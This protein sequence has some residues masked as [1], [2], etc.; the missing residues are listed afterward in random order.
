[1]AKNVTYSYFERTRPDAV[2]PAFAGV[3]ADDRKPI[4][5]L[6]WTRTEAPTDW[7]E[8]AKTISDSPT[9]D[10]AFILDS[11]FLDRHEIPSEVWDSLMSRKIFFTPGIWTELEPWRNTPFA[12]SSFRDSVLAAFASGDEMISLLTDVDWDEPIKK[13]AAYYVSLLAAR[14]LIGHHVIAEFV[15]E[16]GRE[17]TPDELL[18]I[19]QTRVRDRGI[20]LAQK[21]LDDYRKENFLADEELVVFAVFHA[22]LTG[23]ET[24]ILTRDKDVLEQFY[25]FGYLLDTHY[26]SQL[27]ASAYKD[28]PDNLI[29]DELHVPADHAFLFEDRPLSLQLPRRFSEW[30]LPAEWNG[31]NIS[32]VRLGGQGDQMKATHLTFHVE[33]EMQS[34]LTVKGS[35]DG[36]NAVLDDDANCHILISPPF[37]PH[38]GGHAIIA[39][40]RHDSIGAFSGP[41]VDLNYALMEIERFK[42]ISPVTVVENCELSPGCKLADFCII[43][44]MTYSKPSEWIDMPHAELAK[45]I[46]LFNPASIFFADLGF[47]TADHGPDVERALLDKGFATTTSIKNALAS[48]YENK[49]CTR[50]ASAV[51][52]SKSP[53]EL[54]DVNNDY[55]HSR[56]FG[57]YVA[58]LAFRKMFFKVIESDIL[59]ETGEKPSV[60]ECLSR[61]E[62]VSGVLGRRLAEEGHRRSDDPTLFFGDELLVTG[63]MAAILH[64]TDVVVLTQEPLMMDQFMKLCVTLSTDYCAYRFWKTKA[65]A[66]KEW[67]AR[68]DIPPEGELKRLYE[69]SVLQCRLPDTWQANALPNNPYLVNLHCWLLAEPANE[70]SRLATMTFCAE[71]PMHDLL[72][73]K[74][75]C[76]GRNISDTSGMNMRIG[77]GV[78][79]ESDSALIGLDRVV[80]YGSRS[81]A[82]DGRLNVRLKGLPAADLMFAIGGKS[83]YD[84]PCLATS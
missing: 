9:P 13:S 39:K 44:R 15:A 55:A 83:T 10:A 43:D 23:R 82:S 73:T 76:E 30:V 53:V 62:S 12:H 61:I 21:G 17:P 28:T 32:C 59:K 16:K 54:Y 33:R 5:R 2:I 48:Y 18:A 14:K 51:V 75:E 26:R 31:V 7:S 72:K 35:N 74:G 68:I 50:F 58:L 57:H 11:S 4:N 78:S 56:G 29:P 19:C 67:M 69:S 25:K 46:S 70:M 41:L 81:L 24:T 47:L 65:D 3:P 84:L 45:A 6:F 42:T 20:F 40:D 52:A 38:L 36:R 64:G 49:A 63:L 71:R 66:V 1:M 37:S 8:L 60:E 22:I 80:P 27:I 34:I 77:F 79:G